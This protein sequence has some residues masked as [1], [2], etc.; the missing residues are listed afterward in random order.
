MSLLKKQSGPEPKLQGTGWIDK[1]NRFTGICGFLSRYGRLEESIVHMKVKKV[2]LRRCLG[3]REMKEKREL[4]RIVKNSEGLVFFD[5]TGKKNGRGAYL[6]KES[7]CFDKAVKTKAFSREFE[8][9]IPDIVYEEI[10]KQMEA[11]VGK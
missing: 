8:T 6:C 5:P 1:H 9:E 4:L 3:C 11:Y 2:P 10:K 7:A